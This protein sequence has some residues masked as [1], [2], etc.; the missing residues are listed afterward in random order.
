[1]NWKNCNTI[2][3]NQGVTNN[4]N[5][6][7]EFETLMSIFI[8][9]AEMQLNHYSWPKSDAHSQ[10][11][12]DPD[13]SQKSWRIFLFFFFKIFF[14]A[15]SWKEFQ[16]IFIFKLNI[17]YTIWYNLTKINIVKHYYK[18]PCSGFLVSFII[19]KLRP[20][21]CLL[22]QKLN[23]IDPLNIP[24]FESWL[25]MYEISGEDITIQVVYKP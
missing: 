13:W 8:S 7:F 6:T 4:C 14:L 21:H 11:D 15:S 17:C 10:M 25:T 9:L 12:P 18:Y 5:L 3:K 20:W 23:A 16:F 22:W 1:M 2:K 24:W 19:N